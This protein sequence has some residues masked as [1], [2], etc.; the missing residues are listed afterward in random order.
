MFDSGGTVLH[1]GQS[2]TKAE[3][4]A[5]IYKISELPFSVQACMG[6][7]DALLGRHMAIV[8]CKAL[9][10]NKSL[11]GKTSTSMGRERIFIFLPFGHF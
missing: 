4:F 9:Q 11:L 3:L 10:E 1:L 6:W 2:H 7:M 5:F 8:G